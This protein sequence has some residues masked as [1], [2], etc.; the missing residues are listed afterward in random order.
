MR[1]FGLSNILQ[2]NKNVNAEDFKLVVIEVS[3]DAV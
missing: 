2:D 1:T 3:W